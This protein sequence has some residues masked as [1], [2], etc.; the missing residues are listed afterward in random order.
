ML[1]LKRRRGEV[2][3]IGEAHIQVLRISEEWVELGVSAPRTVEVLHD[4][5]DSAEPV[6]PAITENVR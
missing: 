1:I 6:G 4:Q 3:T 5:G 2:I